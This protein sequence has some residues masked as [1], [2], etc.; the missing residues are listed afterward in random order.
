M[1]LGEYHVI[2]KSKNTELYHHGVKGMRWG[3]RRFQ[4]KDGSLTPAGKFRY[5]QESDKKIVINKDGS[6]TVPKGYMFNRVG[7]STLDVNQ[8]GGLY[9]SSG[10]K[11]AARYV[12]NLGPTPIGKLLGTAGEAIQHIKVKND[13]K[14]PSDSDVA[15]ETAKILLYDKALMDS[16]NESIYSLMVT[17]DFDKS[18]SSA[19][20]EAAL[21]DPT[22]KQG[23]R[24]SYGVS[25][26]LGDPNFVKES[27]N[28]Y[29]HF[30]NKGYDAIPDVHDILSGTSETAMIVINPNKVEV[31]SVTTITKDI[32][33]ESKQYVK[34]LE[35]LKVSELIA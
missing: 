28:V 17:G 14:V 29:E 26:F 1:L 25:S 9:V 34:T 20:L 7:K 12:K 21:K 31:T 19:D 8:S 33:K 23:Q 15:K 24:L 6:R 16:F 2:R 3:I 30:R 13:L 10:T 22:G 27:K 18:I 11:D 4:N 5:A 35:K 32:M